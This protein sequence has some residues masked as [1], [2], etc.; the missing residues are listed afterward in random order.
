MSESELAVFQRELRSL[1]ER[2]GVFIRRES[3]RQESP[4]ASIATHEVELW[5]RVGIES[6][7]STLVER[8]KG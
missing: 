1:C 4:R 7:E 5:A 6:G 2:F 3:R 8:Q